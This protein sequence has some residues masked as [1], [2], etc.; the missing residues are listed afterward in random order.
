MWLLLVSVETMGGAVVQAPEYHATRELAQRAM[1]EHRGMGRDVRGPMH[2][3]PDR[4]PAA[5]LGF[6]T[7]EG[8]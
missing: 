8:H 1:L 4:T 3:R 7:K 5:Q 6:F 2:A